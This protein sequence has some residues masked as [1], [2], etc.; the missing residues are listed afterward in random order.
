MAAALSGVMH[1]LSKLNHSD[2]FLSSEAIIEKGTAL[3][4]SLG[5][6]HGVWG[7]FTHAVDGLVA[8]VAPY[9]EAATM[10]RVRFCDRT[11]L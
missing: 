6:S 8:T 9:E 1:T 11:N 5:A 7:T 4:L 2:F 3:G 10:L